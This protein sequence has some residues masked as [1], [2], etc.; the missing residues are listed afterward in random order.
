MQVFIK[1]KNQIHGIQTLGTTTRGLDGYLSKN[2]NRRYKML[3]L[4]REL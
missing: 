3:E 4:E 2:T 1:A